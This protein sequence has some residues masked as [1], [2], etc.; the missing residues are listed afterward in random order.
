MKTIVLLMAILCPFGAD[1]M[2]QKKKKTE[3]MEIEK[4]PLVENKIDSASYAF[5]L[6]LAKD[7][8]GRGLKKLNAQAVA[9]AIEDVFND[10]TLLMQESEM[11][12]SIRTVLTEAADELK[13][14]QMA[15]GVQFLEENAKREGVHTTASGLQYEVVRQGTGPKPS[16]ESDEVTVHYK[17]TLIG[18]KV[19]DSSYDRNETISF[20][21]NRVIKGWTEGVQL[22]PVG[23][24]YRFFIPYDLAYGERGAGNDIPPYSALIFD[25]ELFKINGQ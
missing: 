18:G 1:L 14:K 16:S 9:K 15:A 2:A 24:H 19:F 22:M 11:M 8:K 4:K 17:G 10:S 6:S 12:E 7:L 25:V 23:S 21:L 5:G 13:K 20:Q 3:V